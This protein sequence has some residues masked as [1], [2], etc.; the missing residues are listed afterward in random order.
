[1]RSTGGYNKR[2]D[3][4]GLT[5]T[6][7]RAA[8]SFRRLCPLLVWLH[9]AGLWADCVTDRRHDTVVPSSSRAQAAAQAILAAA[10]ADRPVAA[11]RA[12]QHIGVPQVR[13]PGNIWP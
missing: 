10:G 6:A 11:V 7:T 5:I 8:A 2:A 9:G 4:W 13:A 3:P 12:H 1:M